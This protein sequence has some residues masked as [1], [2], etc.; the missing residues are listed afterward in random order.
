MD[1]NVQSGIIGHELSHIADFKQ[2]SLLSM[3]DSGI[4]H[5]FSS[6]Y[7]DR[8]E[9]RTDS[10]C[11]AHGLGYQLLAWSTFIRNTMHTKNWQGAYNTDKMPTMHERYINPST[12]EKYMS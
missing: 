3:I 6:R 12:I 7:I 10:I 1:F 9:F 2:R 5:L 4:Q 11:L 8:V